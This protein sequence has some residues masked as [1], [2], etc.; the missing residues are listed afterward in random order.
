MKKDH[1]G[2]K[3]DMRVEP[4]EGAPISLRKVGRYTEPTEIKILVDGSAS[5][6]VNDDPTLANI[7]VKEREFQADYFISLNLPLPVYLAK[8]IHFMFDDDGKP[9]NVEAM[10]KYASTNPELKQVIGMCQ[11][12]GGALNMARKADKGIR[13]YIE[14]PEADQHPRR[15]SRMMSLLM[16]LKEDYG[17]KPPAVVPPVTPP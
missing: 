16:M 10:Y 3:P 1:S 9:C 17:A 15:Q 8:Y 2:V 13:L 6:F 14:K 12:V 11:L 4:V 5:G 7:T